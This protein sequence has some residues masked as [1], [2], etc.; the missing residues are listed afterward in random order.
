MVKFKIKSSEH[1]THKGEADMVLM[2]TF[3]DNGEMISESV[4]ID[5]RGSF[6]D[7]AHALGRLVA[8]VARASFDG[9]LL[10]LDLVNH[11]ASEALQGGDDFREV[12]K[13]KIEKVERAES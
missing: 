10:F 6:E 13:S 9:D 5:G 7:M 12:K 4:V 8:T 3:T 11:S 2:V 1:G